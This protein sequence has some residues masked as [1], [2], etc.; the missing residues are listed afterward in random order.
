MAGIINEII[1]SVL[2]SSLIAFMATLYYQFVIGEISVNIEMVKMIF[3]I[4]ML[5]FGSYWIINK[6]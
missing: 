3:I 1:S 2:I 5:A 6:I 4:C